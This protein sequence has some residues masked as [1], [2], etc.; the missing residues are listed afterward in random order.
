MLV[1]DFLL[2]DLRQEQKKLLTLSFANSRMKS[3]ESKDSLEFVENFY[4]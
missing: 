2:T 3:G 4:K 1:I